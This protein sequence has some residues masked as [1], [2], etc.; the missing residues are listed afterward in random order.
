M[1]DMCNNTHPSITH[2]PN[3]CAVFDI[4]HSFIRKL[5]RM[6]VDKK[7]TYTHKTHV[8]RK[9]STLYFDGM[10]YIYISIELCEAY[11]W[12]MIVCEWMMPASRRISSA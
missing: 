9:H 11:Y 5:A 1:L 3:K 8:H 4:A 7:K 2:T 6:E 10:N 12:Q